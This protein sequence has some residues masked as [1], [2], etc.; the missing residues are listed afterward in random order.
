MNKIKQ[1]N[2]NKTVS[3]CDQSTPS[4]TKIG[5]HSQ[6]S[7]GAGTIVFDPEILGSTL[8]GPQHAPE[9]VSILPTPGASPQAPFTSSTSTS[10]SNA[11]LPI[12]PR[13]SGG[14]PVL[15]PIQI[16][17]H[18][19]NPFRDLGD[20]GHSPSSSTGSLSSL[21]NGMSSFE[22]NGDD[23]NLANAMF[24]NNG[25]NP[26]QEGLSLQQQQQQPPPPPP[27]LPPPIQQQQQEEQQHPIQQQQEQQHPIQ[28]QQEQQH[29]I[30]QQQEQQQVPIQQLQQPP[31][32]QQH[33]HPIQQQ[34]E[35]QQPVQ[36]VAVSQ[37]EQAFLLPPE[38]LLF[39]DHN[40]PRIENAIGVIE[41]KAS[42]GYFSDKSKNAHKSM[43][44]ADQ[45]S[46]RDATSEKDDATELLEFATS[47]EL[48]DIEY[49]SLAKKL[50]SSQR[51]TISAHKRNTST[52]P[53]SAAQDAN[54]KKRRVKEYKS[55]GFVAP[56]GPAVVAVATAALPPS[57]LPQLDQQQSYSIDDVNAEMTRI[58][59]LANANMAEDERKKRAHH[60]ANYPT[61]ISN[62]DLKIE[63][64]TKRIAELKSS[65]PWEAKHSKLKTMLRQAYEAE[66]RT[67]SS[68]E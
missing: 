5:E 43:R 68:D 20:G 30:Q 25:L 47:R 53:P 50:K 46:L 8:G 62:L 11:S 26:C 41:S 40:I 3:S 51:S 64:L 35:Q 39:Q 16:P 17:T 31:I 36:A 15:A 48:Y 65:Q 59:G 34:Q 14:A 54:R 29:P 27:I 67:Y 22:L 49:E 23:T 37:A 18:D 19:N 7:R 12:A 4:S 56:Q 57:A 21:G 33:Q 32:Q 61:L 28:Q 60:R 58:Q 52:G 45:K 1:L 24:V 42:P 9:H 66:D 2:N 10:A 38:P 63:F 13:S 44:S 55:R 6:A